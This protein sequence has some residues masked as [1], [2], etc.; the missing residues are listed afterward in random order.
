MTY[1]ITSA[2]QAIIQYPLLKAPEIHNAIWGVNENI[3]KVLS[4][5]FYCWLLILLPSHKTYNNP[6]EL[7][8]VSSQLMLYYSSLHTK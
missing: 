8:L 3:N 4:I 6:Y 5:N 1:S 2:T 7:P